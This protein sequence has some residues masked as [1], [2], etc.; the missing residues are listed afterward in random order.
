[1]V[2]A[3]GIKMPQ[4][5]AQGE[6]TPRTEGGQVTIAR[7]GVSPSPLP[8]PRRVL[9]GVGTPTETHRQAAGRLAAVAAPSIALPKIGGGGKP[10]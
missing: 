7:G 4:R 8:P 9:R 2:A 10:S 1:M 3:S 5:V 6:E